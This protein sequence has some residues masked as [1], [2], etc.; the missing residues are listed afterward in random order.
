MKNYSLQMLGNQ[1]D[2]FT[3]ISQN[4][5][6]YNIKISRNINGKKTETLD[7]ISKEVFDFSLKTGY[8]TE[9]KKTETASA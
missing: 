2:F 9:V 8:L 1:N 7:F 6:G 3:I 5:D 4:K